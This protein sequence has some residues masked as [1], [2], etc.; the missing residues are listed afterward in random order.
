MNN[1]IQTFYGAS[2]LSVMFR[3][4]FGSA[5]ENFHNALAENA[6]ISSKVLLAFFIVWLLE[7]PFVSC[8]PGA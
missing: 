7:F 2:I 3:C 5:W 1:R 6:D 8:L 4:V